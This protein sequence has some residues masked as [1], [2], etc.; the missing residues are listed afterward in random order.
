MLQIIE[1]GLVSAGLT[2]MMLC[3]V[4]LVQLPHTR[5]VIFIAAIML[6]LGALL[7]I[8]GGSCLIALVYQQV[9]KPPS[10]RR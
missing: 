9:R 1:K 7:L 6:T 2:L 8:L 4:L 10:D 3:V 5:L